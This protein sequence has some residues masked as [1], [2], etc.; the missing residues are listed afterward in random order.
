MEV[1]DLVILVTCFIG[2]SVE[3]IWSFA[4]YLAIKIDKF[5]YD[6]YVKRLIEENRLNSFE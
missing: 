2:L 6:R 5:F 1:G 3:A 4:E